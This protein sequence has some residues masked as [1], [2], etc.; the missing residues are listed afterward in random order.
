MGFRAVQILFATLCA[1]AVPAASRATEARVLF[2][3]GLS[4]DGITF[5]PRAF[6]VSW[7][8][9]SAMGTGEKAT[10]SRGPDSS[11]P[12]TQ[13]AAAFT[14]HTGPSATAPVFRGTGVFSETADGG[15]R[16]EWRATADKAGRFA[17]AFV[18]TDIPMPRIGG[19][20]AIVDGA[21]V[22]IPAARGPKGHLFRAPASSIELRG[23]DGAVLLRMLSRARNVVGVDGS[24]AMLDICHRRFEELP[25]AATRISLRIGSLE[26]LPLRDQEADF[27]SINLV[28]HHL[29]V[30]SEALAEARRILNSRGRLFI[31]DFLHHNDESMR[32]TYGDRWL[33]FEEGKLAIMLHNAGF[34]RT[35]IRK[36][37][38]GNNLTL[39]LVTSYVNY[40]AEDL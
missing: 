16:A 26:H 13:V 32:V 24:Q 10:V 29:E 37:K 28:L 40:A 2:G 6:S 4:V 31:S 8:G 27:A 3:T 35:H 7:G 38:V 14:L 1:V 33:G 39:L 21:D 34:T 15:I 36:Q 18:G 5:S 19:G 9:Y 25:E 23:P 12:V 20:T 11:G 17:E 22:P 30:P